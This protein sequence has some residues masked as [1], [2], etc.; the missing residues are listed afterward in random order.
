MPSTSATGRAA[1]AEGRLAAPCH[2]A[3]VH[4]RLHGAPS[5]HVL[6]VMTDMAAYSEAL[7]EVSAARGEIPARR[8]YPGCLSPVA[9]L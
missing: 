3:V 9:G 2:D 5:R 4:G 1:S 7:R 6:V 8:A